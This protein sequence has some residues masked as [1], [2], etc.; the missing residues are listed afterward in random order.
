MDILKKKKK[1]R[2]R[3]INNNI[4]FTALGFFVFSSISSTIMQDYLHFPISLPELLLLPF[5]IIQR[6]KFS[7]LKFKK[8]DFYV[9]FFLLL[10]LL[11]LGLLF[12]IFPLYALLSSSRSWFYLLICFF[13]FSR[14][15][16]FTNED[17]LWLAFGSII[18]WLLNSLMNYNKLL[19][20]A[21]FNEQVVTYGLMLAIPVFFASAIYRSRYFL[22]LLGISLVSLTVV[23]AG[24][25]RLLV[26]AV[27]SLFIASLFRVYKRKVQMFSVLL[28]GFTFFAFFSFFLPSIKGFVRETSPVM[29]YRVFERT[30]NFIES[31]N[32]GSSGDERR[33]D[34]FMMFI[35]S[36]EDHIIPYGMVSVQTRN[37]KRT[38]V[39]NDFPLYQLS[40]IFGWPIA[41]LI[42]FQICQILIRN[43]RKYKSFEDETSFISI[44]CLVVMFLLLFLEGTYIEYPYATPI[45]GAILGRACLN[46]NRKKR[47]IT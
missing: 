42:L 21:I 2:Y 13:V 24:I 9:T 31:G 33:L 35:E 30:E 14:H 41:F 40:W 27:L 28:V 8:K 20:F 44:N 17:F 36:L 1:K 39:F 10:I 15:N 16:D 22:L 46:V 5:I 12:D 19:Q 29:Y 26:I 34:N 38:G 43:I 32:S 23:F 25:R 11:L 7:T 45:T 18:A 4:M 37:D 47:F 6:K 3:A